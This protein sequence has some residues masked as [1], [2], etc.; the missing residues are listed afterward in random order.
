MTYN[1]YL[2]LGSNIEPRL[3]YLQE[4]VSKLQKIGT[5]INKSGV[6]ESE[7]WG[8]DYQSNFFNAVINFQTDKN[9]IELLTEIKYIETELGRTK[10][11]IKWGPREIDIDILF[12]EGIQIAEKQIEIPHKHFSKRKFVLIPMTE[13]NRDYQVEGSNINIEQYLQ[14]C[15][16]NSLVTKTKMTW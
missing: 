5:V 7:P 3:N 11:G 9:P 2:G 1:Y 6:Y 15:S 10:D 8:R 16:D 13:L 4:A 12:A 14:N